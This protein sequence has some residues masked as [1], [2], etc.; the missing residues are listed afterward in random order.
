MNSPE[1]AARA[2]SWQLNRAMAR[3]D[4]VDTIVADYAT[5]YYGRPV[6]RHV[7]S[8]AD[9]PAITWSVDKEAV[10][11]FWHCDDGPDRL[12]VYEFGL[13]EP[14][15]KKLRSRHVTIEHGARR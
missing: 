7:A 4:A 11:E 8:V 14:L 9:Q 1:R 5:S 15:R 6:R 13:L 10:V 12:V 2:S 3:V